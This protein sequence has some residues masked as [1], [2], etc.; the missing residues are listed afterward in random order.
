MIVR[1][2]QTLEEKQEEMRRRRQEEALRPKEDTKEISLLLPQPLNGEEPRT[3]CISCNRRVARQGSVFCS[4]CSGKELQNNLRDTLPGMPVE[5][6][7]SPKVEK[8][9]TFSTG[10]PDESN[11]DLHSDEDNSD[12]PL[13]L[14][15]DAIELQPGQ[16]TYTRSQVA[17]LLGISCTTLCRWERKGR[18]PQP[19][20]MLHNKQCIYT[21]EIIQAA[22][23]YL[24]QSYVPP[25][26]SG[27]TTPEGRLI[28]ASKKTIKINRRLEKAVASRLGFTR[29]F[30]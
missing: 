4:R 24:N 6:Q 11:V 19:L 10:D 13:V 28:Y 3:V 29:R 16:K 20:R 27:P 18:I 12:A 5:R 26:T 2:S 7:D 22:R 1:T 8:M 30:L 25:S 14:S 21:D 9:E 15:P 23:E 17:E